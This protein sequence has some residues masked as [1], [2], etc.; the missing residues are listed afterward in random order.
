MLVSNFYRDVLPLLSPESKTP[1]SLGRFIVNVGLK[2]L[3][4]DSKKF[5]FDAN[6]TIF[7][8]HKLRLRKSSHSRCYFPEYD[9]LTPDE[10][11][12]IVKVLH[13]QIPNE[14]KE[15]FRSFYKSQSDYIR[16]DFDAL[17]LFVQ[18]DIAIWKRS[19]DKADEWLS[20]IHLHSPNHWA[21]EDKIGKSFQDVHRP[22]PH[23]DNISKIALKLFDQC[24]G[25]GVQQR[26]AWG[27][28]TD[29][30]LDHHPRIG[31]KGR[32]FDKADPELYVRIERQLIIPVDGNENLLIFTIRTYFV[33]CRHLNFEDRKSIS[34]CVASMDDR[35]LQYKGMVESRDEIVKFLLSL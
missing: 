25:R 1:W 7:H 34:E 6:M 32:S 26:V 2:P 30:M 17:C 33:D 35:L 22:V 5:D 4:G 10:I 19:D 12:Q 11:N 16:D 9:R 31:E 15:S 27:L 29:C 28:A 18:E 23:I 20:A 24:V 3:S 14:M 8:E 13:S 21:A